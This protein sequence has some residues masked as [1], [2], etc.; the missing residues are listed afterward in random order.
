MFSIVGAL[1]IVWSIMWLFLVYD[2]PARHPRI[3]PKEK[4]YIESSQGLIGSLQVHPCSS[5]LVRTEVF[6]VL[7]K[8]TCCLL[9]TILFHIFSY[10]GS[11]NI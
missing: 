9:G 1:G 7:K 4:N 2:T 10:V 3:D 5:A 6:I 11:N 8:L